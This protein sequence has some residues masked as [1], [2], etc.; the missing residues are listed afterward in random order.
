MS[1]RMLGSILAE[2]PNS[3]KEPVGRQATSARRSPSSSR[4]QAATWF[5]LILVR[6]RFE[7]AILGDALLHKGFSA[8][9]VNLG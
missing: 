5:K 9:T 7:L 3:S 4:T 2:A 1:L 8:P 6:V